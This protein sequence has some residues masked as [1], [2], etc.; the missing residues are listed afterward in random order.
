M[1]EKRFIK[2]SLNPLTFPQTSPENWWLN[3]I[4]IVIINPDVLFYAQ[5]TWH[6]PTFLI[7][8]RKLDL[9]F[10]LKFSFV[11]VWTFIEKLCSRLG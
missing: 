4:R 3:L 7:F 6:L 2:I 8:S 10:E 11:P 1:F 5:M 9:D